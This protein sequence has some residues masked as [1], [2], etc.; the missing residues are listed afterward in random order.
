MTEEEKSE[1]RNRIFKNEEITKF[2][3]QKMTENATKLQGKIQ[4]QITQ[5]TEIMEEYN[6]NVEEVQQKFVQRLD[7]LTKKPQHAIYRF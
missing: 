4:R 5:Y 6:T 1:L 3:V 7:E 2:R